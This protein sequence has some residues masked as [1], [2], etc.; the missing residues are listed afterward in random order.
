MLV[1]CEDLHAADL[2]SLKAIRRLL[3]HD[4]PPGVVTAVTVRDGPVLPQADHVVRDLAARTST[5]STRLGPLGVDDLVELLADRRTRHA[6]R[7]T[8]AQR[9]HRRSGGH[10]LLVDILLEHGDG[11]RPID[12]SV[13]G[14]VDGPLDAGA[15]TSLAL[16]RLEPGDTELLATAALV[17]M[18]IDAGLVAEVAGRSIAGVLDALDRAATVGIVEP[19]RRVRTR[20]RHAHV[21]WVLS[22]VQPAGWRSQRH[23]VIADVLERRNPGE[24]AVVRHRALA[25]AAATDPGEVRA[26]LDACA[27]LEDRLEWGDALVALEVV[28]AQRALQPWLFDEEMDFTLQLL[29]GRAYDGGADWGQARAAFRR[30]VDLAVDSDRG[31]W[32]VQ[33]AIAA[34]GASQPMEG[35]LERAAWL[36]S[37]FDAP[38]VGISP[39]DRLAALAEYVYVGAL[40]GVTD[41]I[42]RAD[43]MLLRSADELGDPVSAAVAAHG[44]LVTLLVSPTRRVVSPPAR[45]RRS[46]GG[47]SRPTSWSASR[48]RSWRRRC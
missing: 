33:A 23:S 48:P 32:L 29:L 22:Q 4:L 2:A 38:G 44:H 36:R 27:T 42:R 5:T 46:A 39:A 21:R 19:R 6:V 3:Q 28:I 20:F 18:D 43:T 47:R 26:V 11:D 8:D 14:T 15:A 17:G 37:V 9:L 45:Q 7:W 1:I 40:R 34:G 24:A 13:D 31:D 25:L 30:A 16:A 35:D 10:P 41:E 12:G